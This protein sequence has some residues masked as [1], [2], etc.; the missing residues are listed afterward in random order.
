MLSQ[1]ITN[2]FEQSV[3]SVFDTLGITYTNDV[4]IVIEQPA[5]LEHGD[6]SSNI[7]MQ[8]AKTLR[9]SPLVLAELVKAELQLQGSYAALFYRI[10]VATPGFI[11]LYIDWQIWAGH[12]FELPKSAG[13]KA[14]IE[15][16]SINPNK[17]GYAS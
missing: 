7:A 14:I 12:S 4:V 5:N 11:N 10:E 9:K 13:D 2:C 1:I 8:L 16:T 17:L 15:H 3:A 6:Y